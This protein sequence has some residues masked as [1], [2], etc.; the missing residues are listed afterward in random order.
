MS[1]SFWLIFGK[2]EGGVVKCE[3][4]GEFEKIEERKL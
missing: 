1:E 2:D 4:N 3:V